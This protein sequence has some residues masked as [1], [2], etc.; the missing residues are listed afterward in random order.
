MEKQLMVVCVVFILPNKK[1][2]DFRERFTE[3]KTETAGERG[4]VLVGSQGRR[5]MEPDV[6]EMC[7]NIEGGGVIKKRTTK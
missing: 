2:I 6:G 5:S 3:N 4:W 1:Q 7:N